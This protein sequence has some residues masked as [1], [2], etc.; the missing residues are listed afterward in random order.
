M[1]IKTYPYRPGGFT[2][3]E[4]LIVLA[5]IGVMTAIAVPSMARYVNNA[6]VSGAATEMLYGLRAARSQAMAT[7]NV[8]TFCAAS[9]ANSSTCNTSGTADWANGWIM[10]STKGG[11][12][13]EDKRSNQ[14]KGMTIT[15]SQTT[16]NALT[17]AAGI[18]STSTLTFTLCKTG[19][20][21]STPGRQIV[22]G[23]NGKA[24]IKT[25]NTCT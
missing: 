11:T 8:V 7:G 24:V 17:F 16:V 10:F 20:G 15:S 6:K 4:V 19:A 14:I 18:G 2:L 25:Y 3:I 21:S 23:T 12:A 5:L 9:A 22:V 1:T 13:S